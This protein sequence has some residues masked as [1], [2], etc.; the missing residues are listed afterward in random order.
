MTAGPNATRQGSKPQSP[1]A[2]QAPARGH[3]SVSVERIA[4]ALA[5]RVAALLLP[6]LLAALNAP[7]SATPRMVDAA[8]LAGVLGVR[9]AWVYEHSAEL[10]AS[11]LGTGPRGRL[12]FDVET[13]RAAFLRCAGKESQTADAPIPIGDRASSRP[14]RSGRRTTRLPEPGSIL[15]SKPA[16]RRA[17]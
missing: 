4:E 8:E 10:G 15:A 7:A 14:R 9:R 1:S 17:A 12:R 13:A 5:P 11:R 3:T 6:Q 16:R 2:G